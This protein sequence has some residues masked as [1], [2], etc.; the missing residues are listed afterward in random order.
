MSA[1]RNL[2]TGQSRYCWP[3]MVWASQNEKYLSL[4]VS[5][6][7]FV[8][9]G[10]CAMKG[11]SSSAQGWPNSQ[12]KGRRWMTFSYVRKILELNTACSQGWPVLN[13]DIS[14]SVSGS[15]YHSSSI[16]TDSLF[17]LISHTPVLAWPSPTVCHA[18]CDTMNCVV[19]GAW[20]M[21]NLTSTL[22]SMIAASPSIHITQSYSPLDTRLC[23][24][25]TF[26]HAGWRSLY[27]GNFASSKVGSE[28]REWEQK[29]Q[30]KQYFLLRLCTGSWK[31]Y[32]VPGR[33]Y[34]P[35][36][37]CRIAIFRLHTDG[38]VSP[39]PFLQGIATSAMAAF[40]SFLQSMCPLTAPQS[41]TG[42]HGKLIH[43]GINDIS[44]HS[45]SHLLHPL[46]APPCMGP[47]QHVATNASSNNRF[48]LCI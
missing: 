41:G 5:L 6:F 39:V 13:L 32:L 27:P 2:G 47:T 10:M 29:C 43:A 26:I 33:V 12:Q 30:R 35:A 37:I 28:R 22:W 23:A 42:P 9:P 14:V 18:S 21:M 1:S 8:R 36:R 25:S 15:L 40:M 24:A 17:T 19:L 20:A 44:G 48:I 4:S 3:A 16:W 46:R 7:S 11:W 45:N 34:S 31:V 38:S